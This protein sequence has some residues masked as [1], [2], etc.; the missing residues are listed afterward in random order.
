MYYQNLIIKATKCSAEDAEEIE[1]YMRDI[2]FHSTLDWQTKAQLN[3]GARE[4]WKDIQFIRS[5]EGKKYME[6]LNNPTTN[7]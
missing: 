4:S 2:Y 1:E 6:T 5:P 7:H 3:K